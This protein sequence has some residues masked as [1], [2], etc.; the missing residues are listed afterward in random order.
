MLFITGS[1]IL[2]RNNHF[3]GLKINF[4]AWSPLN[5][6]CWNYS[7]P[8]HSK[9]ARKFPLLAHTKKIL[10]HFY[11]N[12]RPT[13]LSL[14]PQKWINYSYTLNLKCFN[15]HNFFLSS[16]NFVMSSAIAVLQ[17]VLIDNFVNKFFF[18][19]PVIIFWNNR[20]LWLFLYSLLRC[21]WLFLFS[22]LL[23][24]TMFLL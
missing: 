20:C 7:G 9:V 22:P 4:S 13:A 10:N 2:I 15:E 14:C 8:G 17:K 3:S 12:K 6:Y 5:Q 21:L 11:L 19:V 18:K 1:G 23:S 24:R 16:I